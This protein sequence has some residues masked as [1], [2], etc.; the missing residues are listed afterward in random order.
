MDSTVVGSDN[1]FSETT[2]D[3]KQSKSAKLKQPL[4][5]LNAH[6]NVVHNTVVRTWKK[7]SS[8]VVCSKDLKDFKISLNKINYE[9]FP[10]LGSSN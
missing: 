10:L 8:E 5:M 1:T 9:M 2:E 6:L 3:R 4:S 7:P